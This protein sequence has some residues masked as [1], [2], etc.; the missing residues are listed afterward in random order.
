MAGAV[1]AVPFAFAPAALGVASFA[2]LGAGSGFLGYGTEVLLGGRE[3]NWGEA[4]T[5]VGLGAVTAGAGRYIAGRYPRTP[6]KP[7]EAYNR[8]KHYGRTP[9]AADRKAIGAGKNQVADHD[10]PLVQRYYEGDPARGEKPGWQMTP[11]ERRA[12][13]NDR[14]RMSVQSKADSDTQGG[15]M[16]AY[17]RKKRRE[18]GL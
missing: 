17:S 8:Q 4:A 5:A 7:T 1:A 6:A 18:H 16:S 14:S 13:A 12:S 10:P 9:T 2:G 3:W 15:K 11:E